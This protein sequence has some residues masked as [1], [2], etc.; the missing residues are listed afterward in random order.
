MVY[1]VNSKQSESDQAGA[2]SGPTPTSTPLSALAFRALGGQPGM[3][4]RDVDKFLAGRHIAVLSYVR[5]D[6]RPNQAPLWYSY[7]DGV[8][9]FMVATGSAKELAMRRD[10]RVSVLIQD[11][12]PPYRTVIVDGTAQ[13]D[14]LADEAD[15]YDLAVRYFGRLGADAFW[16]MGEADRERIGTTVISIVPEEVKGFDNTKAIGPALLAFAR[17]RNRLPIPRRWI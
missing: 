12:R 11:E 6:G 1:N 5:R 13:L 15:H 10:Q 14:A 17:L 8:M 16:K 2:R 4:P 9:R 3:A 7:R